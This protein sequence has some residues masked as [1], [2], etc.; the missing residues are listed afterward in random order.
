MDDPDVDLE[1]IAL[2]RQ[3]LGISNKGEDT[4]SCETGKKAFFFPD[5]K[6]YVA[7]FY[8]QPTDLTRFLTFFRC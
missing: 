8:C 2:L 3:S 4:V 7:T 5:S 6:S 1:L